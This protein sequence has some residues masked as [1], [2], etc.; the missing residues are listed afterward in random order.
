MTT[1]SS[2]LIPISILY[3]VL[4]PLVKIGPDGSINPLLAESWE[5]SDD[6]LTYTFSLIE[7]N[8]H[9]GQPLT[10]ADVKYTFE[11][12]MDPAQA[13]P[14]ARYFTVVDQVNVLGAD[15]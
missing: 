6:G 9:D 8:F 10:A 1:S 5:I 12:A 2:S 4:E 3:N 7:A 11:R 14:F 13:H 15:A